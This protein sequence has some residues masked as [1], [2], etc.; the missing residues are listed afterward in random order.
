MQMRNTSYAARPATSVQ[1]Y[2]PVPTQIRPSITILDNMLLR[3]QIRARK[4]REEEQNRRR[5]IAKKEE[6]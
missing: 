5:R 4:K 1:P 3:R 6:E 2:P